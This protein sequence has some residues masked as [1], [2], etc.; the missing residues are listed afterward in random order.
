MKEREHD[1]QSTMK[2]NFQSISCY[3]RKKK[4]GSLLFDYNLFERYFCE[5][6]G[7]I[8]RMK[9]PPLLFFFPSKGSVAVSFFSPKTRVTL[10]VKPVLIKKTHKISI[11]I[12]KIG[13]GKCRA[14]SRTLESDPFGFLK[15]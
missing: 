2:L 14:T 11:K 4:K 8:N 3:S 10:S 6:D 15:P 5:I 1:S 13:Q 9:K 7:G 12:L